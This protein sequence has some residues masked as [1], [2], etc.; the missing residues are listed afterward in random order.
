M[1]VLLHKG[2]WEVQQLTTFSTSNDYDHIVIT[3]RVQKN[4]RKEQVRE[5]FCRQCKLCEPEEIS[6]C[7]TL[8]LTEARQ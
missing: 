6:P 3:V 4:Q 5:Q 2:Y 8:D 7:D 1:D